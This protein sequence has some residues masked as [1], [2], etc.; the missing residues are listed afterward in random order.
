M[1]DSDDGLQGLYEA[2]ADA[3]KPDTYPVIYLAGPIGNPANTAEW[4]LLAERIGYAAMVQGELITADPPWLVINP[5]AAAQY[6][7]NFNI[8]WDTWMTQGILI[9]QRIADA[10]CMLPGWQDSPGA[11]LELQ[12]ARAEGKQLYAWRDECGLEPLE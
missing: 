7:G 10:I 4:S 8:S 3:A 2:Y 6:E 5:Y 11:R 12:I 1:P 9:V